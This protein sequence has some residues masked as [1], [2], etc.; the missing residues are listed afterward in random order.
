MASPTTSSSRWPTRP[1]RRRTRCPASGH[2]T[3]TVSRAEGKEHLASA[4]TSS[5]PTTWDDE[6]FDVRFALFSQTDLETRLRILEGRRTRLAERLDQLR[7]SAARTRERVDEYTLELQ[8][9]G[10][11]QVEREVAWLDGL[12]DRE[13]DSRVKRRRHPVPHRTDG[14]DPS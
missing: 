12:I 11:D 6:H 10:L 4:L 3:S 8:R 9:H 14:R 1:N 5:G 7:T 13:R 2:A